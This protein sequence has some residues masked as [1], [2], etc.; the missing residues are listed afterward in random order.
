MSFAILCLPNGLIIS[1]IFSGKCPLD[2]HSQ[3]HLAALNVF[4]IIILPSVLAIQ[5]TDISLLTI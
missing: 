1:Q 4:H 3:G 5:A 2:T